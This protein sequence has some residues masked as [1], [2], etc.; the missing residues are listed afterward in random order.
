M[1]V[2]FYDRELHRDFHFTDTYQYDKACLSKL[3][4]DELLVLDTNVPQ[5]NMERFSLIAHRMVALPPSSI[6]R[7]RRGPHERIGELSYLKE[8]AF[9]VNGHNSRFLL[10]LAC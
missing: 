3:D 4:L 8:R 2:E 5:T 9:E 7:M 1:T 10:P 6:D